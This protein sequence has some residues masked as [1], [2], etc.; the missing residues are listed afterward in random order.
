MSQQFIKSLTGFKA[1]DK[2]MKCRGFQ[3]E[4][5]KWYEVEGELALCGN[6]FHFCDYWSGVWAYYSDPGSRVFK[7]EAEDV[8]DLAVEPGQTTS[9]F[10]G[11]LG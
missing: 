3:F 5:G 2:D 8:L 6:G 10:V 7:I 1:T 11:A 9:V 4:L